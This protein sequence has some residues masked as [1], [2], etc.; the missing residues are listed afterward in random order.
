[1][2]NIPNNNHELMK[3]LENAIKKDIIIVVM[4]QCKDGGVSDL[5]EPG[6]A[7]V[8]IGAVLAYDMTTECIIS[9][10]SYL[11]GKGYSTEDVK[12]KIM[13]SIRGELTDNNKKPTSQFSLKNKEMVKA[14]K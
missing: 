8:E 9:K 7:L 3:I 6:R 1:M 5:Y 4:S 12:K 13:K 11:I 14:L 2:G 10:L